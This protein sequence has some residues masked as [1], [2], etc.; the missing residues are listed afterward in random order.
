MQVRLCLLAAEISW[1]S[2]HSS[3]STYFHWAHQIHSI[4]MGVFRFCPWSWSALKPLWCV[5]RSC[6]LLLAPRSAPLQLK[7]PNPV[8]RDGVQTQSCTGVQDSSP[9]SSGSPL[10]WPPLWLKDTCYLWLVTTVKETS[11]RQ[12]TP[13]LHEDQSSGSV[14]QKI[15]SVTTARVTSLRVND[16]NIKWAEPILSCLHNSY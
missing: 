3:A 9:H 5:T 2:A 13:Q 14:H 10:P 4:V 7:L 16:R 12:L 1:A 11:I 15:C 8:L 6:S